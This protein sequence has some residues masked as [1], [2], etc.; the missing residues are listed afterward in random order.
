MFGPNKVATGISSTK[1][2][3]E[4][5]EPGW[6]APLSERTEVVDEDDGWGGELAVE[7]PRVDEGVTDV[8]E[9]VQMDRSTCEQ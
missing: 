5:T 2:F 7:A 4:R 9:L 3:D 8:V 1:G 6:D